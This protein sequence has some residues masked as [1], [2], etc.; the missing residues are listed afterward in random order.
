M[1]DLPVQLGENEVQGA[2]RASLEVYAERRG[3]TAQFFE[4]Y[5]NQQG[6]GPGRFAADLVGVL[7]N[8]RILMLEIK[9]LDVPH[10]TLVRFNASQHATCL[11]LEDAGLPLAYAFN[12]TEHLTYYDRLR[13]QSWPFDTLAAIHRALP[14]QLP[15]RVPARSHPSLLHWLESG[16]GTNVASELGGLL[17]AGVTRPRAWTNAALTLVYS[18]AADKLLSFGPNDAEGL[19]SS[20]W[21]LAEANEHYQSLLLPL[22]EKFENTLAVSPV[23]DDADTDSPFSP[24]RPRGPRP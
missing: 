16:Q 6:G 22:F 11:A 10:Y 15:G 23:E 7:D 20:L 17:G 14:S 24:P 8:A 4:P 18:T 1:F 3:I 9:A 13:A 19:V 2:I 5:A 12:G 21:S